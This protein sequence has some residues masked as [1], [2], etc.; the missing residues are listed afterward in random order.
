MTPRNWNEV[1][2]AEEVWLWV[3]KPN[4]GSRKLRAVPTGSGLWMR[5]KRFTDRR[6]WMNGENLLVGYG[7]GYGTVVYVRGK[8]GLVQIEPFDSEARP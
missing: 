7:L 4:K 6:G 5:C 8:L 2:D 1:V 3:R